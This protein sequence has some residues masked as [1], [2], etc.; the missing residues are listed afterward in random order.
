MRYLSLLCCAALLG[1]CAERQ[2]DASAEMEGEAGA[3]AETAS[4]A[5]FAG[6]WNIRA[7]NEMGDS[8]LVEYQMMA[9]DGMDGWMVMFPDREPLPARVVAFEGDSLVT[10]V[11][12]Y[13]SLFRPGVMVTTRS[14]GRLEGGAM[15]G[16]F[17]ATYDTE[18]ADSILRGQSQGTRV[19]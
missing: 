5:D 4:L 1:G 2:E 8:V 9:T 18:E 6:T 15:V 16:S 11:G 10:E 14:V 13:E 19:Q 3:M 17:V 7:L 12:P